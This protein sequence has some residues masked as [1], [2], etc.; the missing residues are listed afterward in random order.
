MIKERA[1]EDEERKESDALIDTL[2]PEDAEEMEEAKEMMKRIQGKWENK[3]ED[4]KWQL[5][6][7]LETLVILGKVY[8][9]ECMYV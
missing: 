8:Y 3:R 6:E 5:D 7:L 2:E 9:N 4:L 1:N